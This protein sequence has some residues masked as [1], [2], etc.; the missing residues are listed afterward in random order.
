MFDSKIQGAQVAGREQFWFTIRAAAPN[1]TNRVNDESG[2]Q[3]LA[4]GQLGL[5]H[6]TTT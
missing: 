2:W 4:S 1:G 5:T 6:P 3:T